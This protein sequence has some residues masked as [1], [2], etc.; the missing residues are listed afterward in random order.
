MT[1]PSTRSYHGC[2]RNNGDHL[3]LLRESSPRF[4][5]SRLDRVLWQLLPAY[6]TEPRNLVVF[7]SA[8]GAVHHRKTSTS[9]NPDNSY[10][11]SSPILERVLLRLRSWLLLRDIRNRRASSSLAQQ[12]YGNDCANHDR[13]NHRVHRNAMVRSVLAPDARVDAEAD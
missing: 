5:D 8:E 10:P 3:R 4:T 2:S 1:A 6:L 12:K 9:I 7:R 11:K 13:S